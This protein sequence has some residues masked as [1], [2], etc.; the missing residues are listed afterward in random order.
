MATFVGFNTINQYKKF[1][2]TDVELVQRDLLNALNIQQGQLPG[3][4][5]YGTTIWSFMFEN[6]SPETN[7][8]VLQ[9]IQRVAAGDPRIQILDGRVYGQDN[10]LLI[11]ID[12]MVV[13]ASEATVLT[14]F[15][16]QETQVASAV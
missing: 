3:R 5:Q 12:V 14:L 13:P 16:N 10:G 6:Q 15:F 9:E 7:E 2:L 4:P 1:T 11:E 8:A